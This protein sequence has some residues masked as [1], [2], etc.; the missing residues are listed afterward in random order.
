MNLITSIS[1]SFILSNKRSSLVGTP[2][3]NSV[4]DMEGDDVRLLMGEDGFTLGELS[5]PKALRFSIGDSKPQQLQHNEGACAQSSNL[6]SANQIDATKSGCRV[7]KYANFIQVRSIVICLTKR[8]SI[9]T[10][11]LRSVVNINLEYATTARV[12][13]D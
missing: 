12:N 2:V 13:G 9:M 7:G 1:C 3:S 10:I 11:L 4:N 6:S 8:L 5:H